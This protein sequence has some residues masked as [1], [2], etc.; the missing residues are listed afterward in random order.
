MRGVVEADDGL[1]ELVVGD[2][3]AGRLTDA[4]VAFATEG[5]YIDAQFSFMCARYS[6]HIVAD[7]S[8]RA[9]GEDGD[10]LGMK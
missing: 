9:G 10:R 3:M 2:V 1:E 6:V 5:E 8:H 7:Q 4:A